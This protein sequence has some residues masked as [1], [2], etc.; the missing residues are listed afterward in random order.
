M[1]AALPSGFSR[2]EAGDRVIGYAVLASIVLHGVLLF[3]FHLRP[4][5]GRAAPLP[6]I[7]AHLAPAPAPRAAEPEPPRSRVEPP[8]PPPVVKSVPKPTPTPAP[9]AAVPP[10]RPAPPPPPAPVQAAPTPP[11][12]QPAAPAAAP[13][14]PP[15]A[16]VSPQA[17]ASAQGSA[18]ADSLVLF[19]RDLIEM[20]K[21]YKRYPRVAMDNN[22]EGRVVVRLVIGS[23]GFISSIEVLS[24]AGHE[25]LDKQAQDMLRRAKTLVQIPSALRGKEFTIEIP[26]VYD[27]KE[28]G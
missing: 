8:P 16:A 25:V 23:N 24:S 27:L 4:G 18:E 13:S 5:K 19:R 15:V 28:A 11:A 10:P 21:K 26:V 12:P 6:P 22:W 1:S 14:A 20:A 9:K 3:A 2:Y 7:V 17:P